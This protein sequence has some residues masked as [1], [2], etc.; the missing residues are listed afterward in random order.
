M[1]NY[2][3]FCQSQSI[4][5]PRVSLPERFRRQDAETRL[6]QHLPDLVS[7]SGHSVG[8]H[9]ASALV[10]GRELHVSG[11]VGDGETIP[12]FL[13]DLGDVKAAVFLLVREPAEELFE[14]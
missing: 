14:D 1:T 4:L 3:T 6:L 8:L 5:A 10:V 11:K 7:S 13:L 9:F 12:F 2:Q